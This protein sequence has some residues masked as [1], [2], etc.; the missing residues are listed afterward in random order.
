MA[1]WDLNPELR[2]CYF[3]RAST[4]W[5]KGKTALTVGGNAGRAPTSYYTLAFTLQLRK[6]HGE[7]SVSV[8]E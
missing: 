5:H 4:S 7:T 3:S 1:P 8:V 2:F 6:N